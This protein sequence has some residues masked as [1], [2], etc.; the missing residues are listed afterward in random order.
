MTKTVL[1]I[2]VLAVSGGIGWLAGRWWDERRNIV[3]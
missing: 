1:T 3:W 2:V